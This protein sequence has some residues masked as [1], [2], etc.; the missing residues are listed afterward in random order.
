MSNDTPSLKEKIS[1]LFKSGF[2]RHE[3]RNDPLRVEAR[4]KLYQSTPQQTVQSKSHKAKG[5]DT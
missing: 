3:D 1:I 4:W 5:E 2:L